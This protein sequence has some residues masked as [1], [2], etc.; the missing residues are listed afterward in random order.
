[1]KK[2]EEYKMKSKIWRRISLMKSKFKN[3]TVGDVVI[4]KNSDGYY[5]T[6]RSRRKVKYLERSNER[7][8]IRLDSKWDWFDEPDQFPVNKKVT[9]IGFQTLNGDDPCLIVRCNKKA[10]WIS[11]NSFR[12]P[13]KKDKKVIEIVDKT[14][15]RRTK[16]ILKRYWEE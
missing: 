10:Y 3:Y 4:I 5:S 6:H 1:M 2:K 11:I 15:P 16:D 13:N 7:F 9:I 8:N 12:R 14:N